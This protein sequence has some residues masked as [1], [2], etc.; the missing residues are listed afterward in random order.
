MTPTVAGPFAVL[1]AS[2]F[3]FPSK[4]SLTLNMTTLYRRPVGDVN[5]PTKGNNEVLFCGHGCEKY[6]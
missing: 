3:T 2:D 4:Y 6:G 5:S 1:K